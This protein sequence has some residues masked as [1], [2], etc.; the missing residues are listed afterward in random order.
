MKI[1]KDKIITRFQQT[2]SRNCGAAPWSPTLP[3]ALWRLTAQGCSLSRS[4]CV[5]ASLC[6]NC[7]LCVEAKRAFALPSA[8]GGVSREARTAQAQ[9]IVT[10]TSVPGEPLQPWFAQHGPQTSSIG[11][12][13]QPVRSVDSQV[14][15]RLLRRPWVSQAGSQAVKPAFEGAL[16]GFSRTCGLRVTSP[17]GAELL[18]PRSFLQCLRI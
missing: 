16:G 18:Q 1:C 17:H 11:I 5:V 4:S 13:R 3:R 6:V 9:R 10:D 14:P 2:F 12:S 15:C 8:A 7:D